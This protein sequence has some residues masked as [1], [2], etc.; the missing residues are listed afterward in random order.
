MSALA[1]TLAGKVALITGASK[2]IGRATALRLASLGASTVINYA[3][4][5]READDLVQKIGSDRALAVKADA[6][7][8]EQMGM[9]VDKTVQKFGKIDILVPNAAMLPMSDLAGTSEEQFDKAMQLNVKGPYFLC[10]KAAPHMPKGSSIVLVSS[11]VCHISSVMPNYLLYATT[12]GAIE[13]MTRLMAKDLGR[14]GI[15]VNAVAP[16]PTGTE[17]FYQGKSEQLLNMIR[18]WTP[19][20]RIGEPDEIAE[21]IA[22]LGGSRW[23][24]GQVLKANGGAA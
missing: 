20:N 23:V 21:V 1:S 17:L 3:S 10:Q 22:F 15:N 18:G 7:S 6:G 13:Q 19:H 8:V 12:K 2:G 14:K 11:T 16:G 24:S 4:S 5:A 9:L